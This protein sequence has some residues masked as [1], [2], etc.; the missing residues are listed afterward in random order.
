[1]DSPTSCWNLQAATT[2]TSSSPELTRECEDKGLA[3][4]SSSHDLAPRTNVPL[5]E[6]SRFTSSSRGAPPSKGISD[7][8]ET[9]HPTCG[10]AYQPVSGNMNS[11]ASSPPAAQASHAAGAK[12][13]DAKVLHGHGK[14]DEWAPL[15]DDVLPSKSPSLLLG[16]ICF[17][18]TTSDQR[19]SWLLPEEL[20][21]PQHCPTAEE[22]RDR[23]IFTNIPVTEEEQQ[24]IDQI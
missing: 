13:E 19:G 20:L 4:I 3:V 14:Y 21:V 6:A 22:Q 18:V 16:Q 11:G 15:L 8:T 1:M 5:Q 7:G 12:R 2:V 24:A 10:G 9:S 17:D 23:Q